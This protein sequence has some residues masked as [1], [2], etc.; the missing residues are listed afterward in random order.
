MPEQEVDAVMD[1]LK[2]RLKVVEGIRDVDSFLPAT[3]T[4]L[5]RILLRYLDS[6]WE[7]SPN[8]NQINHTIQIEVIVAPLS[9]A[10][11][12]RR[13]A[14]RYIRDVKASLF[15]KGTGLSLIASPNQTTI[16]PTGSQALRNVVWNDNLYFAAIIIIRCV[17]VTGE[18]FA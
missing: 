5:P 16:A 10:K 9:T 1:A 14:I 7:I 13:E 15:T 3:L 12:S 8:R 17:E 6:P 11:R 4:T 2:E 18:E